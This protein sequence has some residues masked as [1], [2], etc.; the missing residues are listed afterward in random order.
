MEYW[1]GCAHPH[2]YHNH[3]VPE[4]RVQESA[5]VTT[6]NCTLDDMDQSQGQHFLDGKS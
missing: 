1:T 5:T 4:K 2:I 3:F 6:P